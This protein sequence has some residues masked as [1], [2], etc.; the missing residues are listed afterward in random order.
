MNEISFSAQNSWLKKE[1]QTQV[2]QELKEKTDPFIGLWIWR[3]PLK[4]L[5]KMVR[6]HPQVEQVQILRSWPSRFQVIL[7]SEEPLFLLIGQKLFYPVT[8]KGKL[9]EPLTSENIPDLPLLRGDLFLKKEPLR[10]KAAELFLHLPKEG[11]FSQSNISEI[12]YARKEQNF[13][14]YLVEK[15][16][17]V[18]VGEMLP[19]FRPDRV[20]SVLKYLNQKKIKWRVIDARFSQKVIVS[21]DKDS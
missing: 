6:A 13:Y 20:E 11:F 9:L 12:K 16:L 8:A 1:D 14:F 7:L 3:L 17:P 21:L 2:I 10:Q 5:E 4:K 19:E 18:R 15:G